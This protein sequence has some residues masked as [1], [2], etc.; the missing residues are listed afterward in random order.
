MEKGDLRLK[1][2]GHDKDPRCIKIMINVQLKKRKGIENE[3]DW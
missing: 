1:S 2:R 3:M